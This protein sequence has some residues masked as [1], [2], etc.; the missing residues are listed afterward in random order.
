M[1]LHFM[2]SHYNSYIGNTFRN[3]GAGVAVMY[4]HGIRMVNNVFEMNTGESVVWIAF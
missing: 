2:S 1:V 4:T 3:N